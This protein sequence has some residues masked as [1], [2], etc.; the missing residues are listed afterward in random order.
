MSSVSYWVRSYYV[1]DAVERSCFQY[2]VSDRAKSKTYDWILWA[3]RGRLWFTRLTA[4]WT[5]AECVTPQMIENFRSR[6][7]WEVRHTRP[8]DSWPLV[9]STAG[10]SWEEGAEDLPC[11]AGPPPTL[12]DRMNPQYQPRL[13]IEHK[14]DWHYAMPL[15]L[16]TLLGVLWPRGMIVSWRRRAREAARAARVLPEVRVR[17]ARFLGPL[18]GVR[19]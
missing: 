16:P 6:P 1:T 10:F 11:M 4:V 18:P 2:D 17:P 3:S 5:D 15:W 19:G 12:Y 9:P 7:N 8:P 13:G 14:K